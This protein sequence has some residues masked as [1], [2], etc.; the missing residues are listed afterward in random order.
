MYIQCRCGGEPTLSLVLSRVLVDGRWAGGGGRPRGGWRDDVG[1]G[2]G[3]SIEGGDRECRSVGVVRWREAG[4]GVVAVA[5]VV[6]RSLLL[7]VP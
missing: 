2:I 7:A 1:G 6:G 5:V 4:R 3:G